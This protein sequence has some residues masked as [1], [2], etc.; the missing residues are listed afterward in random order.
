MDTIETLVNEIVLSIQGNKD[1]V[2]KSLFDNISYNTGAIIEFNTND[3]IDT[4]TYQ[5]MGATIID[6]VLQAGVSYER[7]V[8]PRITN[9]RNK[10]SEIKTTSD[11]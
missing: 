10:H 4:I 1:I 8:R 3:P 6:A 5:N 2:F 7:A 9:F 11:F